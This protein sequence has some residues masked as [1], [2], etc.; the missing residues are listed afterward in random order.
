[1]PDQN[2]HFLDAGRIAVGHDEGAVAQVF[3]RAAVFAEQ[4]DSVFAEFPKRRP[5]ERKL[6]EF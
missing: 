1:M 5:G 3:G 4:A 6:V 2:M